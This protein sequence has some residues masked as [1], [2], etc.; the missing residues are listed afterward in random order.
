MVR[1]KVITPV[2]FQDTP[3][4]S[5]QFQNGAIKSVTRP[6]CRYVRKWFQF[7]N[8]AIKSTCANTYELVALLFQFQNGAIKSE[9]RQ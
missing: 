9:Y 6:Y 4:P 3:L 7:Q 2:T 1:L 8:G 5:F